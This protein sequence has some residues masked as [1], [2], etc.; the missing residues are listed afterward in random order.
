MHTLLVIISRISLCG[1]LLSTTT[2]GYTAFNSTPA[3]AAVVTQIHIA[4]GRTPSSMTISWVTAISPT[5]IHLSDPSYLNN[6]SEPKK[7][8]NAAFSSAPRDK[9]RL[10]KAK[11]LS[12]VQYGTDPSH[13]YMKS[14][15]SSSSYTFNYTKLANY[16]SG[17]NHHTFLHNLVPGTTYFYQ[18]G[19]FFT[20]SSADI[21]GEYR[22]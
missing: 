14:T 17:L 12:A 20:G 10:L 11:T 8:K 18:C 7:S 16:T 19:D 5:R 9:S 22:I 1:V 4:Q 13:L 21:S 15:G 2:S 3:V 6:L